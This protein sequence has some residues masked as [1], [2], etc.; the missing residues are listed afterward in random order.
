MTFQRKKDMKQKPNE[1]IPLAKVPDVTF[2]GRR[3]FCE[4]FPTDN[5]ELL[6]DEVGKVLQSMIAERMSK[7]PYK[8]FTGAKIIT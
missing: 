2:H 4:V 6:V 7:E 3:I 8:I 1:Q 5:A